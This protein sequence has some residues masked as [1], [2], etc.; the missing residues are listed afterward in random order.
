MSSFPIGTPHTSLC[1][2][3]TF[4]LFISPLLIFFIVFRRG[5]VQFSDNAL[6]AFQR[7]PTGASRYITDGARRRA[8]CTNLDGIL[9]AYNRDKIGEKKEKLKRSR[10]STCKGLVRALLKQQWKRC[11]AHIAHGGSTILVNRENFFSIPKNKNRGISV[12]WN[13]PRR[14][15]VPVREKNSQRAHVCRLHFRS[16]NEIFKLVTNARKFIAIIHHFTINN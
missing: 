15:N 16:N 11:R 9:E 10:T 6:H 4:F 1:R 7:A 12:L 14:L 2:I 13:Y 5:R 8:V 3:S